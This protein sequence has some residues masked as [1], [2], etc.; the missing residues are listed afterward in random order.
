MNNDKAFTIFA[1]V[2]F[3]GVTSVMVACLSNGAPSLPG[4]VQ[5]LEHMCL[6][7]GFR[8]AYKNGIGGG[9]WEEWMLWARPEEDAEPAGAALQGA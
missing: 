3:A 4:P 1:L 6:S 5:I 9:G 2:L 7:F 8:A